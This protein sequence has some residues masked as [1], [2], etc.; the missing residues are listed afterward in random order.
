MKCNLLHYFKSD[1]I[2]VITS[3]RLGEIIGNQ[4][5]TGVDHQVDTRAY[6]TRH[7][8]RT[9]NGD[10]VL[11][12]GRFCDRMDQDSAAAPPPPSVTQEHWSL[13]FDSSFTLNSVGGGI[14]LISPKGDRLLYV[15]RLHFRATNNVAEYEALVNGLCITIELGIQQLYI[16]GDSELVVN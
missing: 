9:S 8:L 10:Q 7:S 6:G 5:T 4:L 13:Y 11:D 12:P 1:P 14:V 2:R 16:R 3:F 15:I